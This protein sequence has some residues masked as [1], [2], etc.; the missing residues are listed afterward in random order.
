MHASKKQN[1]L[2]F[3]KKLKERADS[4]VQFPVTVIEAPMGYG[5]T[6][7]AKYAFSET[8]YQVV[9]QAIYPQGLANFWNG[10]CKAFACIDADI[11]DRLKQLGAPADILLRE[12]AVDIISRLNLTKEVFFV[13][14]DY[15]YVDSSEFDKFF[16]YL[17]SNMPKHFNLVII[18][19]NSFLP[20][21]IEYLKLKNFINH[22]NIENFL[23]QPGDIRKYFSSAG[24]EISEGQA[25]ELF[26][27]SEGWITPLYMSILEYADT[28][29]LL[30]KGDVF[31]LIRKNI[32]NPLSE[33]LRDLI[34]CLCMFDYFSF[35]QMQYMWQGN[36]AKELFN[37]FLSKN[38]FITQN[39]A[40]GY[41]SFHNLFLSQARDNFH[42][43]Q[44]ELKIILWERAGKWY[45]KNKESM[46]A[47]FCFEKAGNYSLIL[48]TLSQLLG[49][50]ITGEDKEKML[51]YFNN[52]PPELFSKNLLALLVFMRFIIS[53]NEI[54][55]LA[56]ICDL[57]ENTINKAGL[58]ELERKDLL[59][60]YEFL[61]SLTQYNNIKAMSKHHKRAISY[62][63]KP[64]T[65]T[66][67]CGSWTF[68]CPSVLLMFYRESGKLEE[69]LSDMYEC[70]PY[71]YQFTD[72]HGSGAE[73]MMQAETE[74][75]RGKFEKAE[76]T[77]HKALHYAQSKNQ[78]SILLAA[79]F[80][81]TRLALVKGD[82]F[83]AVFLSKQITDLLENK[84]NYMLIHTLDLCK[85]YMHLLLDMPDKVPGWITCGNFTSTKL[86]F[87]ALPAL[88]IV[89]GRYLLL[90]GE[91]NKLIGLSEIFLELASVFPNIMAQI[92]IKIYLAACYYKTGRKDEAVALV[93]QELDKAVPDQIYLPF[94]ENGDFILDLLKLISVAD[95]CYKE[96]LE[97]IF[98]I[99][100]KI[101]AST[102]KI[103]N[104]HLDNVVLTRRENDVA[105]LVARGLSNGQIAEVLMISENT[106]K[107]RLKSIFFKHSIESR[108]Q[109]RE[110]M[111][112]DDQ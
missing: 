51:E 86:M 55:K 92:Y 53:Y 43:Q 80:L 52:C 67:E 35:E 6:T 61:L 60:E 91:Y 48:E 38:A 66:E 110:L 75:N 83:E 41:Y 26:E 79:S 98:S 100:K 8:R 22:I 47:M 76:A 65:G 23:L 102:K 1:T 49:T 89:Y 50:G 25:L 20:E 82:Y 46:N 16:L 19:R 4:I 15:H 29:K 9:W 34:N 74:F 13:L 87:P 101:S 84:K 112:K 99:Y 93:K 107:A 78:W 12:T 5:K 21:E 73:Y 105:L 37:E 68:G 106:V 97:R 63:E 95:S 58:S 108:F 18:S 72:G 45:L 81:Q 111:K 70:M 96:H 54:D 64:S 103:K 109:L 30:T 69:H 40:T 24:I 71:Y 7:F 104:K 2:Y 36:D 90:K 32:Y 27:Y 56:E 10:F 11:A 62:M 88:H 59:V 33:R 85:A 77:L 57:F 42:L 28:G 31:S 17:L 39:N 3:T 44:E 14:D 94:V